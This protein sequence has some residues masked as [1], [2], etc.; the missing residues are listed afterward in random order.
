MPSSYTKSKK[1]DQDIKHITKR[2]IHD[3]G[4]QQTDKYLSGLEEYLQLL[5]DNPNLGH[6]YTSS[7]EIKIEYYYYRYVSHVIY[8]RQRK[9]DIFIVR[10]LHKKMLPK[11]HL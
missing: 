4:E 10:I 1:T 2:S 7:N 9:Q 11:K 8:Y 3:F 6:V 5:A